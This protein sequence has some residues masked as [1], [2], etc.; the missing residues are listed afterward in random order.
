MNKSFENN[1]ILSEEAINEVKEMETLI[2]QMF[3]YY[4][5]NSKVLDV[6]AVEVTID[7]L[8]INIKKICLID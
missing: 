6:K 7:D 8:H 1:H 2:Y 5:D 4:L 3:D